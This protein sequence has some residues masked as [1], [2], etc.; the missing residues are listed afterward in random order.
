MFTHC[1]EGQ[2]ISNTM[3]NTD[4]AEF[5]WRRQRTYKLMNTFGDNNNHDDEC[6]VS[7][8]AVDVI[9]NGDDD[10]DNDDEDDDDTGGDGDEICD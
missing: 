7:S 4:K 3:R 5:M 9:V 8:T 1:K 6:D 10:N 2:S